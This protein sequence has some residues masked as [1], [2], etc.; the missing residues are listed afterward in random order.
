MIFVDTSAWICLFD[1]KGKLAVSAEHFFFS[2]K[3]LLAVTDLIIEETHKWLV[4]HHFPSVKVLQILNNFVSQKF[5]KIVGIEDQDRTEA[6]HLVQKYL[7]QNLSYTDAMTV[8]LMKKLRIRKVF[9]F[10]KHFD[11]FR[12]IERVP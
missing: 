11:L 8:T 12:G 3:E 6:L 10:D 9:S 2:N 7:D 4:Q 5:A 1:K